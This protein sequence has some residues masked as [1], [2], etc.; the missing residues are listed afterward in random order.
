MPVKRS[1]LLG[2]VLALLFQ[3]PAAAMMSPLNRDCCGGLMTVKDAVTA[4]SCREDQ[5]LERHGCADSTTHF[6]PVRGVTADHADQM[7]SCASC[8]GDC[9]GAVSPVIFPDVRAARIIRVSL[10]PMRHQATP[11]SSQA[12]RCLERPPRSAL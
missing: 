3:M 7:P 8:D 9:A 10:V 5:D 12:R 11:Y 4:A 2:L 1:L 6:E